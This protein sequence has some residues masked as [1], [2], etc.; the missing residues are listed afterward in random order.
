MSVIIMDEKNPTKIENIS[1]YLRI[2][3]Y[4]KHEN[5][6]EIKENTLFFKKPNS[7]N[8]KQFNFTEIFNENS[9]QYDVFQSTAIPVVEKVLQGYNGTIFA[10]GQSGSGKTYTM[11]GSN[12]CLNGITP[13]VFNYIFRQIS[14]SNT[15]TSYIITATYLEIYNEQ[16][17]DLLTPSN[18]KKTLEI[19]ERSDLGVFVKDLSG[20]IVN[21]VDDLIDLL[22][23]GNKNRITDATKLN[24]TSSRSHAIFQ[25]LIESRNCVTNDTSFGKLNLVDLAGSERVEKTLASGHQLKE[26]CNINRSLF[27][28]GN[29]IT[30][31]IDGQTMRHIPYRNSKLTRLLKDSLGGNSMT[32]MLALISSNGK[33]YNESLCTLMYSQRVKCVENFICL[34]LKKFNVIEKFEMKINQL[35]R[36][37]NDL[38]CKNGISKELKKIETEKIVLLEKIENLQKK[39]LV[40]GV[41]LIEKAQQQN[42]MIKQTEKELQVLNNSNNSLLETLEKC[43]RETILFRKNYTS[44]QEEDAD[45]TKQINQIQDRLTKAKIKLL[46]KENEYQREISNLLFVNKC[47]AR[48]ML[49]ANFV[50]NQ[51]IPE[52]NYQQIKNNLIYDEQ[53]Q[54]WHL[55]HIAITGNNILKL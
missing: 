27:V 11:F 22:I 26:S 49:L 15:N 5:I 1:V 34:N 33:D 25:I 42:L 7:D 46:R 39:I 45:L 21:S 35:K 32:I 51:Y 55:K 44:L 23:R 19:R 48:E 16:I 3:P 6:I 12:E 2:K 10:Y 13:N 18:N 43:N 41:N 28:L 54:E 9:T 24:N 8:V 20:Y 14:L 29:V 52:E 53:I 40:G 38:L 30:A 50:I 4:E 31:L 17:M 37:L 47:L 36:E